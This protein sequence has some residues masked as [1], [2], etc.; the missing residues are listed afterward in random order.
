MTRT[1]ISK[2]NKLLIY[3]IT[4][5]IHVTEILK[6]SDFERLKIYACVLIVHKEV[7]TANFCRNIESVHYLVSYFCVVKLKVKDRKSKIFYVAFGGLFL[8]Y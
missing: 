1:F 7:F 6:P 5:D 3:S 8:I 2:R 4:E